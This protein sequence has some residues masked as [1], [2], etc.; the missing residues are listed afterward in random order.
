M[1][2]PKFKGETLLAGILKNARATSHQYALEKA[3]R[4][5]IWCS[6]NSMTEHFNCSYVSLPFEL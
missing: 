4:E 3:T 5:S 2:E 1:A 6:R